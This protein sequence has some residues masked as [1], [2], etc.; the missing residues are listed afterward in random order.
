[1]QKHLKLWYDGI[2]LTEST[3]TSHKFEN[4]AMIC[5][6]YTKITLGSWKFVKLDVG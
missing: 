1:M 5:S 4:S 6:K 2:T 3:Q